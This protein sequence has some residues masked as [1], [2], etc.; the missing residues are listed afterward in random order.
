MAMI[1]KCIRN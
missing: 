1:P